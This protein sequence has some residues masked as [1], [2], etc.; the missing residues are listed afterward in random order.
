[1]DNWLGET[2][3]WLKQNLVY[4]LLIIVVIYGI[5]LLYFGTVSGVY[6][7]SFSWLYKY[8][9]ITQSTFNYDVS[10]YASASQ[11]FWFFIIIGIAVAWLTSNDKKEAKDDNLTTKINHFFPNVDP[12]S[13]HMRFLEKII[14]KNSCIATKMS[15]KLSITCLDADFF[16]LVVHTTTNLKNI[17]H[18]KSI[19]E[20]NG[21]F[22]LFPDETVIKA[23]KPWGRVNYFTF[24]SIAD[25]ENS[26]AGA[27]DLIKSS[28][29]VY[30]NIKLGAGELGKIIANYSMW[31]D[32]SEPF[33]MTPAMF[34]LEY[35][36]EFENK[37][38]QKLSID[39]LCRESS[40]R[41]FEL[42]INECLASPISIKDVKSD[43]DMI[44]LIVKTA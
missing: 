8:F 17:H 25:G 3:H 18:N 28:F 6:L 26:I 37:T 43:E 29:D 41:N 12:A 11:D 27:E 2:V 10:F 36:L 16:E 34:T 21:A 32:L 24:E 15:S 14:N 33:E 23:K 31:N 30:Y 44:K 13:A 40:V 39:V 22:S 9:D 35:Q 4:A 19:D 5:G 42:D 1:M 7:S 20:N 38:D